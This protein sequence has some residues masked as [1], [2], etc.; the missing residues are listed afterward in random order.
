[1]KEIWGAGFPFSFEANSAIRQCDFFRVHRSAQAS[2]KSSQ[3]GSSYG[4]NLSD[5]LLMKNMSRMK[6]WESQRTSVRD[7][8]QGMRHLGCVLASEVHPDELLPESE[9]WSETVMIL[10]RIVEK[11]CR[12]FE[13]LQEIVQCGRVAAQ[14][15]ACLSQQHMPLTHMF[16]P[17][18]STSSTKRMRSFHLREFASCPKLTQLSWFVPVVAQTIEFPACGVYRHSLVCGLAE[19]GLAI[20]D[21]FFPLATSLPTDASELLADPQKIPSPQLPIVCLIVRYCYQ[22]L[23]NFTFPG[24]IE[25]PDLYDMAL[26]QL[27]LNPGYTI[28]SLV[29]L[30][31]FYTTAPL[32]FPIYLICNQVEHCLFFFALAVTGSLLPI[33]A[34]VLL[35][36]FSFDNAIRPIL[37][38]GMAQELT[39]DFLGQLLARISQAERPVRWSEAAEIIHILRTTSRREL[40]DLAAKSNEMAIR[41]LLADPGCYQV[42]PSDSG[43]VLLDVLRT[44]VRRT[45]LPVTA[46]LPP[47]AA[48]AA[49]LFKTDRQKVQLTSLLPIARR[50][51]ADVYEKMFALAGGV[52]LTVAAVYAGIPVLGDPPQKGEVVRKSDFY[53]KSKS[54]FVIPT[55]ILALV[56]ALMRNQ[57]TFK[58]EHKDLVMFAAVSSH[59]YLDLNLRLAV[60]SSFAC[61]TVASLLITFPYFHLLQAF[62]MS[63]DKKAIAALFAPLVDQPSVG[64]D[65]LMRKLA[66]DQD[67]AAMACILDRVITDKRYTLRFEV[68]GYLPWMRALIEYDL[69]NVIRRCPRTISIEFA[70]RVGRWLG[71][72]IFTKPQTV[73][74]FFT[75]VTNPAT[76]AAAIL[77]NISEIRQKPSPLVLRLL[78]MIA[79]HIPAIRYPCETDRFLTHTG[80]PWPED[81]PPAIRKKSIWEGDGPCCCKPE[82]VRQPVFHCASCNTRICLYCASR[83]H[84]DHDLKYL[85]RSD[86]C[87]PCNC[88]EV[89]LVDDESPLLNVF[90]ELSAFDS[91]SKTLLMGQELIEMS[92]DV[93]SI[94]ERQI[95]PDFVD[96]IRRSVAPSSGL[97]SLLAK[98]PLRLVCYIDGFLIVG[99][100]NE[101]KMFDWQSRG[102]EVAKFVTSSFIFSVVPHHSQVAVISVRNIVIL[103]ASSSPAKFV[104][105]A[106]HDQPP[107]PVCFLDV[108]WLSDGRLLILTDSFIWLPSGRAEYRPASQPLSFCVLSNDI[109]LLSTHQCMNLI[110]AVEDNQ[111]VVKREFGSRLPTRL[112][113]C[114]STDIVFLASTTAPLGICRSS[115]ILNGEADVV[116][117]PSIAQ[118]MIYVGKTGASSHL[119]L[120]IPG[121]Q[122]FV[123]TVLPRKFCCSIIGEPLDGMVPILDSTPSCL[124]VFSTQTKTYYLNHAGFCCELANTPQSSVP[125]S[126]WTDAEIDPD[127]MTVTTG[128]GAAAELYAVLGR[129]H[130][131]RPPPRMEFIMFPKDQARIAVGVRISMALEDGHSCFCIVDGVR[132]NLDGNK[133]EYFLAFHPDKVGPEKMHRIEIFSSTAVPVLQHIDVHSVSIQN[134]RLPDPREVDWITDSTN[135][136]DVAPSMWKIDGEND[137]VFCLLGIV[138]GYRGG[139]LKPDLVA[140]LIRRMYTDQKKSVICRLFLSKL[141]DMSEDVMPIWGNVLRLVVENQEVHEKLWE[142]VWR[143]FSLLPPDVRQRIGEVL[144]NSQK[145][146]Y[147]GVRWIVSAF[148]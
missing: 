108:S 132:V 52:L 94:Q 47:D 15:A 66:Q 128:S 17:E 102:S 144:W 45:P 98:M 75:S 13:G 126:F 41:I 129:A 122:L 24:L 58:V 78:R 46:D 7:V 43:C 79:S 130:I 18:P 64:T 143:D 90:L 131:A 65:F 124:G 114:P 116:G 60:L 141:K 146:S 37:A 49:L 42:I 109:I 10:I 74:A 120:G 38:L 104:L 99:M 33:E 53:R 12:F 22:K 84:D 56:L 82:L 137:L 4:P 57:P 55:R 88:K 61:R 112:S 48:T 139:A 39:E 27:D 68:E 123:V 5:R 97:V 25:A 91:D 77:M 51:I 14:F 35:E 62:R 34:D 101:V 138:D 9:L 1:M 140:E 59:C 142:T 20:P 11:H 8:L 50:A 31:C 76:I 26:A 118:S 127:C 44:L 30:F 83:C 3:P 32:E 121:H 117:F 73:D 93:Y 110:L 145:S 21:G 28:D 96:R 111:F 106:Q 95:I 85:G 89:P 6:K 2:M 19:L 133:S 107:T 63:P 86:L 105:M 71:S 67:Y 113:Y 147:H 134:F 16:S 80:H 136:F 100:Y 135:L 119:L 148:V 54:P 36:T 87:C 40:V 23:Y 103:H 125:L 70:E 69:I 92:Q 81:R 29:H 115:A 72:R